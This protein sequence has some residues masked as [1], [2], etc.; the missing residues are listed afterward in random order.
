MTKKTEK[1]YLLPEED[2][3]HL[4]CQSKN[5]IAKVMFLAAMARLIFDEEGNDTFSGKK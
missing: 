2:V 4:T 3:P 1:Y 5:Y